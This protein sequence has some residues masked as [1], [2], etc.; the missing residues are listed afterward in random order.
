MQYLQLFT[1]VYDKKKKGFIL[2]IV[3]H[4]DSESS[5]ILIFA[6]GL[7]I[8]RLL[9]KSYYFKEFRKNHIFFKLLHFIIK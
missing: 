4:P 7:K 5:K 1:N 6:Y 2:F 9:R 8:Y 3:T